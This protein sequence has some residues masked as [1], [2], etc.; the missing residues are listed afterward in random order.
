MLDRLLASGR[1]L[2]NDGKTIDIPEERFDR[3]TQLAMDF[4]EFT[5]P[6]WKAK[7]AVAEPA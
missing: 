6:V 5:L 3:A 7:A 1:T 4:L 2:M